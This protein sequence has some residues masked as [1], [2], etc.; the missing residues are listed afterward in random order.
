MKEIEGEKMDEIHR[1]ETEAAED[2]KFRKKMM[3]KK[4]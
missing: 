3:K 4:I 2:E 1:R